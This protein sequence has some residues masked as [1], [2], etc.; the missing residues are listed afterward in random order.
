M[1]D[2]PPAAKSR[3]AQLGLG[4]IAGRTG[5]A[6]AQPRR[7]IWGRAE[8]WPNDPDQDVSSSGSF[9]RL[10]NFSPNLSSSA[11]FSRTQI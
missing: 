4:I 10:S 7:P 1:R 8:D 3:K 9:T 6:A 5:I 11:L 2:F